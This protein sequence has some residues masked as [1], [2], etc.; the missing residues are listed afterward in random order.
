MRINPYSENLDKLTTFEMVK[1]FNN[2]D[3]K[4]AEVVEGCLEPVAAAVDLMVGAMQKGGRAIYLGSGTSGKLAV[5]DASECPPTFGV[6]DNMII[7]V[8]S[9]GVEAVAGWKEETED[10]GELAIRDLMA[11]NLSCRDV[12]VGI[13][14]SGNTPYVLSGIGYAAAIGCRTIG[15][16]CS[17]T[18]ELNRATDVSIVSDVGPEVIEGSTRLKSGTAQKM[19]LNMLSSCTMVKLGKTYGNLMANVRPIN[20]KL[21][22]RAVEI[23]MYAAGCGEEDALKALEKAGDNAKAAIIMLIAGNDA[24]EA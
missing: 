3:K 16:S 12:V 10:D 1:V 4:V 11:R 21:K 5:V 13:S 24:K 19:I 22:R 15:I 18:G 23:I 17:V 6:D 9:G 2:E 7:G 8:I 20:R 14:A